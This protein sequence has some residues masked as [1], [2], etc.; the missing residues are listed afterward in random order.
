MSD[1]RQTLLVIDDAPS[2]IEVI[3][4]IL[5]DKYRVKVATSGTAGIKIALKEPRPDLILLDIVM[6][7]MDGYE[8]CRQLKENPLTASIPILF[9]TGTADDEEKFKGLEL[10][11]KGFLMKPLQ[12]QVV[13]DAVAKNIRAN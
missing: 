4:N 3:K 8:V 5:V 6:P 2:N 12:S 1:D 7:D 10:G 9:V 13:L 11:A